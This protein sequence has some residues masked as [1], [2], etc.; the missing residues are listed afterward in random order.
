MRIVACDDEVFFVNQLETYCYQYQSETGIPVDY[1][2]FDNGKD[3][4]NYFD[5]HGEIDVFILDI[6]MPGL[7]GAKIAEIVRS[8]SSRCTI[9]FLTSIIDYVLRGYEIGINRYWM[10]PLSYKKFKDEM[11]TICEKIAEGKKRYLIEY[12]GGITEK[13]SFDNILYIE[14]KGRKTMV[15]KKDGEYESTTTMAEYE[16]KLDESF[17]RCHAAYIVNLS[18]II[19]INGMEILLENG[20]TI[21]TSKGKRKDFLVAF[22]YA[23]K[24][25]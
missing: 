22:H 2:K 14:T 18:S 13:I 24:N 7:N 21:Y 16:R 19:K 6:K 4:L 15:H 17:Y 11:R 12:I 8:K 9:I 10:K 23:L 3:M 5:E 1:H 25:K 20:D